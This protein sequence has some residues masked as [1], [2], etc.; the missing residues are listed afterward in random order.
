MVENVVFLQGS[1]T[2]KTMANNGKV[3]NLKP[4]KKGQSGNPKGRPKELPKLD[5]MLRELLSEEKDGM[6]A[7]MAMLKAMRSKA[8]KGDVRAFEAIWNR[9][10]GKVKE[11]IEH[12]GKDGEAIKTEQEN[13]WV[14]GLS[15]TKQPEKPAKRKYTRKPKE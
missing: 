2:E 7:A 3:E 9:T 15:Q 11:I 10:F 4:W 8:L 6:T 14:I 12:T 13:T 1:I 5:E